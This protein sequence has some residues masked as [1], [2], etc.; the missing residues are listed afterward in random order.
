MDFISPPDR[1]KTL[2]SPPNIEVG[3]HLAVL[4]NA[5]LDSGG[6]INAGSNS[7][8]NIKIVWLTRG[9]FKIFLK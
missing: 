6:K 4:N 5:K 1:S 9:S 3:L 2:V 8:E 7:G